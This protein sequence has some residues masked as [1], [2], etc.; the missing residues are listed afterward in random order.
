LRGN[1]LSA[2]LLAI[3]L[4]LS[5]IA[6]GSGGSSL[7]S[8]FDG[9]T[10]VNASKCCQCHEMALVAVAERFHSHRFSINFCLECHRSSFPRIRNFARLAVSCC[11]RMVAGEMFIRR[12]RYRIKSS[13]PVCSLALV[14]RICFAQSWISN[15]WF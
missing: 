8:I 10:S 9:E 5:S 1:K 11:E 6:G 15:L 7:T 12:I 4:S 14:A 3:S 13:Q 2:T